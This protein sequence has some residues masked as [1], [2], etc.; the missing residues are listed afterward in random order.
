M[1]RSKGG[2]G[3]E[4]CKNGILRSKHLGG[5]YLSATTSFPGVH[6][7]D[8]CAVIHEALNLREVCNLIIIITPYFPLAFRRKGSSGDA[9]EEEGEIPANTGEYAVRV[10]RH[11]H[12][13]TTTTPRLNL[14][15]LASVETQL[16]ELD[17]IEAFSLGSIPYSRIGGRLSE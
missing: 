16:T 17:G 8:S 15:G 1:N 2:F 10:T 12:P 6:S 9:E 14:T 5:S 11:A 13:C 7:L 3:E 4:E